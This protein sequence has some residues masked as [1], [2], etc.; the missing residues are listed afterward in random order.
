MIYADAMD[1]CDACMVSMGQ[2]RLVC[3]LGLISVV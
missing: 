1:V 3:I 2:L